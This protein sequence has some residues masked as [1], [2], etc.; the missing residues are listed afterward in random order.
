[1]TSISRERFDFALGNLKSGDWLR[2]ERLSSA[3]LATEFSNLRTMASAGG[4]GGRDAELYT[5]NEFPKVM[6]QYSI[7]ESWKTKIKLTL[8]RLSETFPNVSVLIYLTNQQIG[9]QGDD[10]RAEMQKSG[11]HLDIRDRSWFLERMRSDGQRESEAIDFCRAIA[12]PILEEKKIISTTSPLSGSE[13]KAAILFLE[14][15]AHDENS[16]KGLTKSCFESLVRAA[17]N[18]SSA[19]AKISRDQIHQRIQAFLPRHPPNAL[20]QY[21]DSAILRMS[22]NIIKKHNGDLFHLSHEESERTKDGLALLHNLHSAFYDDISDITLEY[23]GGNAAK[24]EEIGNLVRSAIESYFYKL[25]EEFAQAVTSESEVPLHKDS[26][27]EVIKAIAPRG[28]AIGSENWVD[29]L[30]RVTIT[31]L[32]TPSPKT[33]ELFRVLS[34]SYTLFAFLEE[35]PDVQ[36]VTRK[37]FSD[38]N[39]WLDTSAVLPLIAEQA[40]PTSDRPFSEMMTQAKRSGIKVVITHGILQEVER[41]LALCRT[42]LYKAK[43]WEGRVPYVFQRFIIAGRRRE[44]F[45]GWLENFVGSHRPLDDIG[46][47]LKESAG[48]QVV[49][50]LS[51][52]N[53]DLEMVNEIRE[54]WHETQERRRRDTASALNSYRLAEHDIENY[55]SVL[56]ERKSSRSRSP[57]GYTSWLLSLDSAAWNLRSSVSGSAAK[58]IVHSPLI[59]VDYLLKNLSFGP[60]RDQISSASG[61]ARAFQPIIYESISPSLISAAEKIRES[62]GG[63][64]DRLIQRRIRDGIDKQ[65]MELGEIQKAGLNNAYDVIADIGL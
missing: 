55:I 18:G 27:G 9:A 46:D 23:H 38:A 5:Y 65:R 48:V 14:L 21:V 58:S 33:R 53:L 34:T 24:R 12:D 44:T 41:H 29:Y 56:T 15:Q 52:H 16:A 42:Y 31:A 30:S 39:L 35:V 11:I 17:L 13:A 8:K 37:L 28:K 60:R 40:F 6:V 26:L 4:D 20:A 36:K 25:G 59:S 10:L 54:Y 50:P 51:G 2:F 45:L 32:V 7:Q 19:E 1:M 43:E 63:L 22:K 3:F 62:C 57:L 49:D 61:Y 47:F 64:E